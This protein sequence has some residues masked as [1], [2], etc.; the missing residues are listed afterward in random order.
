MHDAHAAAP[1]DT[2]DSAFAA[3]KARGADA[4]GMGVDQDAS[5]HTFEPRPDGGRITFRSNATD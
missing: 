4:K 1:G 5:T 2:T 3:L